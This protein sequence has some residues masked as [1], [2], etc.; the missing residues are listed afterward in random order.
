M[1]A[2]AVVA[3]LLDDEVAVARDRLG[4]R[5]AMLRVDGTVVLCQPR[6][7]DPVLRLDGRGYDA[8]PFRFSVV[9]AAGV[10]LPGVAWPP[11]CTTASTRYWTCR[12]PACRASTSTT[13][14]PAT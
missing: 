10:P 12:S 6:G 8:E 7:L 11:G 3:E 14:T 13:S 9:D 2:A 4:D 5:V 1:L